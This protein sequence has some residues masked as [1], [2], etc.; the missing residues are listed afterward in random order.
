M[1]SLR[2]K[3]VDVKNFHLLH[4]SAFARFTS[5]YE[6][7][8]SRQNTRKVSQILQ[9]SRCVLHMYNPTC[10][11]ELSNTAH[12]KTQPRMALVCQI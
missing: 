5:P 9:I 4:D 7:K 6:S 1:Y 8:N 10:Q 3:P 11:I 12:L 2:I